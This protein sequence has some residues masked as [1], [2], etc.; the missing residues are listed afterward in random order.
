MSAPSGNCSSWLAQAGIT[1]PIA[2]D[3]IGRESGCNPCAYYP[4]SSD[5][6]YQGNAACGI[7]QALPCSKLRDVAGCAMT[8][9][10]CQLRWMQS[11]VMG[12]Y[13]SWEAARAH[14]NA[15]NWY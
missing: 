13:G 11:Y 5:C 10:V 1:H 15:N 8:D 4:S 3:L 7:P 2:V 12:R 9:A 14:H 6:N